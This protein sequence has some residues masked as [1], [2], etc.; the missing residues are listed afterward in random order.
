M[1]SP[2]LKKL[3]A[4]PGDKPGKLCQEHTYDT[5]DYWRCMIRH[6]I[7]TIYHP[8]GT[9]KMGRAGDATAVVDPRLR[10]GK[11]RFTSSIKKKLLLNFEYL[12]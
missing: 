5:D 4:V 3:G 8:S 2:A 9:C 10:Y 12:A 7:H 6:K 11:I 1:N